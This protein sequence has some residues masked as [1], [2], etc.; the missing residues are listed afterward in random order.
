MRG[1]REAGWGAK[2]SG[3]GRSQVGDRHGVPAGGGG[4]AG[5]GG[6]TVAGGNGCV[7]C[8]VNGKRWWVRRSSQTR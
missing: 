1:G 5:G 2:D 4:R 6:G 8:C 3:E 7:L